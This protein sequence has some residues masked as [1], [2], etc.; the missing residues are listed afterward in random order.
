MK[1][2]FVFAVFFATSSLA[3][4]LASTDSPSAE[5]EYR[6][7]ICSDIEGMTSSVAA[8]RDEGHSEK[9]ALKM[10]GK[11]FGAGSLS[12]YQ[13]DEIA[14]GAKLVHLI[15]NDPTLIAMSPEQAGSY[16]SS[17]CK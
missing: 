3:P 11:S 13:L 6:S 14:R 8:Y 7:E 2:K 17:Q 4:A 16:I 5:S 9:E 15:Y 1:Y 10:V 12:Q